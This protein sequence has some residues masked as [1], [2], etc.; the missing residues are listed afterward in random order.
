MLPVRNTSSLPAAILFAACFGA[1]VGNGDFLPGNDQVGNMLFSVN[2][3]KRHSFTIGPPDAQQA[4]FRT[5]ER[6]GAEPVP[7]AVDE[8]TEATDTAYREGRLAVRS[9]FYYVSPTV[10]P[11]V[12]VNTFGIGTPLAGLPV[13]A[14][15]DLFVDIE[16]D[17]F[18]WWHGAALTASLLTALAALFVFLGA[19][20]F[21]EPVPAVLIALAFGLGS[22]A[23]PVSSQALRQHPV[24]T[25]FLSLAAWLLLRPAASGRERRPVAAAWCRAASGMA[26]LCRPTTAVVV[27][28]TG[29]YLPWVDRRRCAAFVLGGLPFLVRPPPRIRPQRGGGRHCAFEDGLRRPVAEFLVGEPA[30]TVDQP[31][32]RPGLVLAGA[33]ARLRERGRGVVKPALP[34]PDTAATGN[35]AQIL[36]AGKWFD[37]W[38]GLTWA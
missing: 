1:Y 31:G 3:L 38:G 36:A 13:Y 33:G 8:W 28:C 24:S 7:T 9:H 10:F 19:R 5:I 2:V 18:W 32:A 4:F 6:P 21:V 23:W 25:F 22:C 20:G 12:Y 26:V 30:R 16:H 11:E 14:V 15:L 35:R 29:A 37:W 17:R 34:R 27:L